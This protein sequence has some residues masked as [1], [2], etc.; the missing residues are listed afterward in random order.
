MGLTDL[1]PRGLPHERKGLG[2]GRFSERRCSETSAQLAQPHLERVVGQATQGVVV[3]VNAL[4]EGG[5]AALLDACRR[6]Q[7]RP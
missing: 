6:A 4:Q 7:E 2:R 5:I 1:A 3:R